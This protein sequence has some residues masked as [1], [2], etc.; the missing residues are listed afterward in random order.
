V[1]ITE[2]LLARVQNKNCL[3][4]LNKTKYATTWGTL[5]ILG[6]IGKR[7]RM[8]YLFSYTQDRRWIL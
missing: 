4:V 6:A 8:Y 3:V 5:C 7:N 1:E 2:I